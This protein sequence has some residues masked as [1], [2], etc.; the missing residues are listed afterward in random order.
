[1]EIVDAKAIV[2][3]HDDMLVYLNSGSENYC[4]SLMP[5]GF[6]KN[7][8][9]TYYYIPDGKKLRSVDGFDVIVYQRNPPNTQNGDLVGIFSGKEMVA[10]AQVMEHLRLM[11]ISVDWNNKT[12]THDQ[13]TALI[14]TSVQEMV[15]G[16]K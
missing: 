15:K 12:V 2:K 1:V 4:R 14:E 7:R 5:L 11:R 9:D 16:K 6:Q 3:Y 8:H 10:S 13:M